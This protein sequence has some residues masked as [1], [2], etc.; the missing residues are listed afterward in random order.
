MT[1][2]SYR[3]Q[4]VDQAVV[5]GVALLNQPFE[6]IV[7]KLVIIPTEIVPTHLVY[8]NTY[9]KLWTLIKLSFRQCSYRAAK[10]HQ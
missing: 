4:I 5:T 8:H 7:A 9:Y 10:E 2:S 6:T 1:N 3:R